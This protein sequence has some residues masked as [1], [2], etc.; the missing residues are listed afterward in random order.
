MSEGPGFVVPVPFCSTRDAR[1]DAV[2]A[3]SAGGGGTFS[4]AGIGVNAGGFC[5]A[6]T[7]ALIAMATA[8]AERDFV[9][10]PSCLRLEAEV[11]I[12]PSPGLSGGPSGRCPGRGRPPNHQPRGIP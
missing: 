4:G 8:K 9:I 11:K 7:V 10:S 12:L 5:C 6:V 2:L 3:A 1:P